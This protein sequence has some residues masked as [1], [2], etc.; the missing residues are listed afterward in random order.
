MYGFGLV[1]HFIHCWQFVAHQ[2]VFR[3]WSICHLQ[4]LYAV[5][6]FAVLFDLCCA[7]QV[8]VIAIFFLFVGIAANVG[9]ILLVVVCLLFLL[10]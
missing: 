9:V 2:F 10:C 4:L 7:A 5:V 3:L 1:P 6:M 8:V